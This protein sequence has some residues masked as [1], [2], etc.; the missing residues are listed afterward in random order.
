MR[1]KYYADLANAWNVMVEN[2]RPVLESLGPA[3][4]RHEVLG[5]K[6]GELIR[7]NE[8]AEGHR[9]ELA[10]VVKLRK[11]AATVGNKVFRRFAAD[12]QA[13]HGF[14]SAE[15]IRYGLQPKGRTRKKKDP[16]AAKSKGKV[17]APAGEAA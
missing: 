8:E 9:S 6:M 7:L 3:A 5:Q 2:A 14:D 13:H 17:G 16:E 4:S 10:R 12:L 15:L 11:E 1:Q